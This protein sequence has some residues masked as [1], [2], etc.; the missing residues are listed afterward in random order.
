MN[1]AETRAELIDP[2]LKAAGWGVVDGSRVRREYL[3]TPGRIEGFG[4]RAKPLKADYVLE[5]R[6]TKLAVIEAKADTEEVSEGVGQA[7]DYASKL[8]VR[9]TYATNGKGIYAIDMETGKEGDLSAYPSPDQLWAMTFAKSDTW[10]DRFATVPYED[11]GGSHPGRYYQDIAIER[12][13]QAIARK[14]NRLLLTLAT[15]TGKTFIAFQIAW[16]LFQSRW[17]LSGEP[18]RRPR[19]L[20]LA[21][22]N[23][24]ANQAY[25]AFSSFPEDALVRIKPE[26]IRKK[27]RVPKNGSLFFTIFQQLA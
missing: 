22:R 17:N 3:I 19:I 25:N 16:K 23:I 15:G 9:F 1:E 18:T 6:N 26:D 10:R 5:Y 20:F 24:L 14:Q 11:K 13:M 27:G 4:R 8:M 21:D 12:V 2:A 7:K